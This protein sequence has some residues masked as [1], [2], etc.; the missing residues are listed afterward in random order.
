MHA[1]TTAVQRCVFRRAVS[2]LFTG[3][4]TRFSAMVMQRNTAKPCHTAVGSAKRIELVASIT[5][6][7]PWHFARAQL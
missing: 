3:R 4:S 5:M 2:R 1:L 7:S 6:R